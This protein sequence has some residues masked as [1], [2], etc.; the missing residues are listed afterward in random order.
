MSVS[1]R[2]P[3]RIALVVAGLLSGVVGRVRAADDL[4]VRVPEGFAVT[5]YADDE[6]AHDI[7]CL[8]IDSHGRVVVSGPGYIKTLIDSDQDGRA[9]S[10]RLLA[11]PKAGAQGL[12]FHGDD[13]LCTAEGGLVRYRDRNGDGQSDG[14]PDLFMRLATGGEHDAH[15]IHRG[16]DGWW[17]LIAGNVSGIGERYITTNTSPVAYPRAGVLMRL[18]P[19]LASGEIVAEGFRNAYDFTFDAVGEIFTC[20][21]DGE[22]DVSLPWYLPSR[23]IHVLPGTDAGWV[24]ESWKRRDGFIDMP[25]VLASLGRGSPTGVICYRHAQFPS[26]YHSSLFILDW[27]YGKVLS[28]RLQQRGSTVTAVPEEFMTGV[29]AHGF[30]PTSGAVGPDGALYIA[31]GGRG[32]RGGVY[33][34]VSTRRPAVNVLDRPPPA[35][36]SEKLM[37]CLRAPEPL[38]SWS[39]R[40][41]EPLA[42]ELGP[43]AFIH[44]VQDESRPA[45]ER[46][47]GV[48]ILTEL[49]QG[50]DSDLLAALGRS[51]RPAVRARAAWALGRS[52][53]R[54]PR[55]A[56]ARKFLTDPEP[57]VVRAGLESLLGADPALLADLVSPLAALLD[58]PDSYIRQAAFRVILHSDEETYQSIAAEAAPTGWRAG[59]ALALIYAA[60]HDGADLYTV[61]V[62]LRVLRGDHPAELKREAVRVL[63]LGLGDCGPAPQEQRPT[64]PAVF[65][66]YATPF[67]LDDVPELVQA[68]QAQL[69]ELYPTDDREVDYELARTLAMIQPVDSGLVDRVLA[70]I[71]KNTSPVDDL[72][73]L[74]V[75]ARLPGERTPGQRE[76]TAAAIVALEA[77]LAQHKLTRD[78]HWDDRVMEMYSALVKTDPLLPVALLQHPDFGQPGHAQY[79]VKLDPAHFETAVNVFANAVLAVGDNYRW[80][81]DV[82]Y[83]LSQSSDPRIRNL[84]RAKFEDYGLR[85]SVLLALSESPQDGDR[86]MFVSGLESSQFDVL[87]ACIRAL[88]LLPPTKT[89]VENVTLVRTLRRL[90]CDGQESMIRDQVAEALRRN[91]GLSADYKL[92]KPGDLQTAAVAKWSQ[93]IEQS[94]PEEFARQTGGD[95]GS[96][97]ALQELLAR[98]PWEQGNPQHGEVLFQQRACIQCHSSG[99]ALGPD[100]HGVTQR[101]SRDDLFTAIAIPSRDVSPRYQAELVV[102]KSGESYSGLVVYNAVDGLVL[103]D[104]NNRT[105]RIEAEEIEVRRKLTTSLMPTGL[106]QNLQPGDLA[107]LYAYLSRLSSRPADQTAQAAG[108]V[109]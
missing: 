27:T 41:W 89:A 76:Q 28:L 13:L 81:G 44:A 4:G 2:I 29:G 61:D 57:F 52:Q 1:F 100:L 86:A 16:P 55:V 87:I 15:A 65:D 85:G 49:F 21:S 66:A 96:A 42:K 102:T 98:V 91:T 31:V 78:L 10:A 88:T 22:R 6:L 67:D 74:I 39:R 9:E 60:R 80:N 69:P 46:L 54:T 12:C 53:T 45:I 107:D 99:R 40:V 56:L 14:P 43:E 34:V 37:S 23:V 26:E 101:F 63:Q 108:P 79:L 38:S 103:R 8:T 109:D 94:Y 83:L 95:A 35:S 19:D 32:T 5:Q 59:L 25:P 11:E 73:Q 47:R 82:V 97:A 24:S 106:L 33:R 75:L 50:P 105:Y 84:V 93:L 70:A 92:G 30:A 20:D 72:H 104:A 58:S 48:E 71:T 64:R 51:S 17:Y 62:A 68:L 90:G 36:I 18:S 3:I 7:H 77:K